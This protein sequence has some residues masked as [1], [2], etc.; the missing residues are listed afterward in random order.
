MKQD[1]G[2]SQAEKNLEEDLL[3]F[4]NMCEGDDQKVF[5]K[6]QQ[7]RT[8][9]QYARL[10][11]IAMAMGLR[12]AMLWLFARCD[13]NRIEPD[14]IFSFLDGT[15]Y[16]TI[17]SWIDGFIEQIKNPLLKQVASEIWGR[18]GKQAVKRQL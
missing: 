6:P 4:I 11:C 12:G 2:K 17:K 3:Y 13:D 15:P 5:D 10:I 18:K 1:K 14:V 16:T 9:G 7:K 8:V